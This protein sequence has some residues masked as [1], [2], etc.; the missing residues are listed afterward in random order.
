VLS[1]LIFGASLVEAG[2]AL[3]APATPAAPSAGVSVDATSAEAARHPAPA[4]PPMLLSVADSARYVAIFGLQREENWKAA[5]AEI[6]GLTDRTLIGTVLA[7]R[8]LS[9]HYPTSL[10]EARDW[11][12]SYPDHPDARAVWQVARKKAPGKA[13]PQPA[14]Q[15]GTGAG[16]LAT[17]PPE[18]GQANLRRPPLYEAGLAAWRGQR[19][20]DAVKDFEA[21]ANGGG[22]SSWYVAAAA[23]WAARSHLALR[24]PEAV[25]TWFEI[26]AR[27]PRTFY[28]LLAR[29]TLGL[30]PDTPL[31][32][33]A[34][35]ATEVAELEALPGGRRA[36]ALVQVGETDRAE[37]ELRALSVAGN[38][39][40]ADAIVSLADLASMPSLCLSLGYRTGSEAARYPVPR[41]EPRNG[42]QIDRALLFALMMEE[43]RFN[44]NVR[45]GSG[46]AGLMQLMPATARSVAR[47][48]GIP[49]RSVSDL[50]DPAL[51]LSLGQE[52]VREL[53]GLEQ[54][55]GNLIL[56][57]A[58]YNT[59]PAPLTKWQ[60]KWAQ[61]DPLL[62]IEGLPTQEARLY[63]QRVLTNLW[64]YRQRLGQDQPDLDALAQNRWPT[65]VSIDASTP[66][67]SQHASAR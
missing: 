55:N 32:P 45:S 9:A 49:L 15:T 33:K 25:D 18:P 26:A 59:G 34:L 52:Y 36:L 42:F 20:A 21:V 8:Y 58:A 53:I 7:E 44:T 64:I 24:Q 19:Y 2:T 65:Y 10:E 54:V 17:L 60:G 12:S 27:Q 23:F 4:R 5:D 29:D 11:L 35:D 14:A 46:A 56:L 50:V 38:S 31:G 28:G 40:L 66:G 62:F 30:A 63:V 51:N 1:A 22:T 43:S 47:T 37:A 41:W 13:M 48:A 61:E 6:A 67:L 39:Q 16:F 57:L 3:S